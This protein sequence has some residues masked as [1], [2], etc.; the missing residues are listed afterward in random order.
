MTPW[1]LLGQDGVPDLFW[2]RSFS[3]QTTWD[4]GA[5]DHTVF[6][7]DLEAQLRFQLRL[8]AVLFW[9]LHVIC[10]TSAYV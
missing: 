2:D 10:G 8:C 9:P 7:V 6:L 3:C 4:H 1:A 5:H